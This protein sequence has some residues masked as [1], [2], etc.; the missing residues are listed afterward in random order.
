MPSEETLEDD[1]IEDLLPTLK[2]NC[3]YYDE[4]QF[5][6]IGKSDCKFSMI[7]INARSLY[8]NLHNIKEFLHNIS[9]PFDILAI[10]ETWGNEEK[11]MDFKMEGYKFIYKNRK[12]RTGGGVALYVN[13]KLTHKI[14][15]TPT[16]DEDQIECLTIEVNIEGW[17]TE[18]GS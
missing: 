14:I 16:P 11:G 18:N 7:H 1:Y 2:T 8:K 3:S 17:E 10:T 9:S 13:E 15:E 6:K 5:N 4:E 12:N